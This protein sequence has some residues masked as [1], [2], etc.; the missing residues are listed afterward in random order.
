MV[1]E[2]KRYSIVEFLGYTEREVISEEEY[3]KFVNY[4]KKLN[5]RK[6]SPLYFG[7]ISKQKVRLE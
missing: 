6:T 2:K 1:E 5:N 7:N 4:I 3:N